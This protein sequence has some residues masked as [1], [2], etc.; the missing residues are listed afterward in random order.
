[1]EFDPRRFVAQLRHLAHRFGRI[2]DDRARGV[3]LVREQRGAR[4]LQAFLQRH[5]GRCFVGDVM[6]ERSQQLVGRPPRGVD[7]FGA[8]GFD[9]MARA[10]FGIHAQLD[11]PAV[12]RARRHAVD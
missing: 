1:M 6:A 2:R 7:Q 10:G 8:A 9:A 3:E 4:A 11:R 5:V 12:L